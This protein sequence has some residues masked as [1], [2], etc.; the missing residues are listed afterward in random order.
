MINK[1]KLKHYTIKGR[2]ILKCRGMLFTE[3]CHINGFDYM[4]DEVDKNYLYNEYGLTLDDM[5]QGFD[6]KIR[7]VCSKDSNHIMW[8]KPVHRT[9]GHWNCPYC[10]GRIFDLNKR[11]VAVELPHLLDE[12]DYEMNELKPSEVSTGS[13]DKCW[14][15]CRVCGESF[16]QSPYKR[17]IG[18]G[19]PYCRNL[20][21]K[22]GLNDLFTT[23]SELKDEWDWEYNIHINPYNTPAG[24]DVKVGWVCKSGH[25]WVATITSRANE[26][27]G[28][29][30][31]L[32]YLSFPERALGLYLSIFF[33][34]VYRRF[35][36]DGYEYDIYMPEE[37]IAIEFNGDYWHR[38]REERD[39]YKVELARSK[40]IHFIRIDAVESGD[41]DYFEVVTDNINL[42]YIRCYCSKGKVWTVTKLV[43][44]ISNHI[45][46]NFNVD[47]N[48]YLSYIDCKKDFNIIE[49][50]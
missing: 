34:D 11:S 9:N 40:K 48:K 8:F 18:Q 5:T 24:C 43:K 27:R 47:M 30:F 28:C 4:I 37:N 31:C 32:S 21:I 33:T 50:F 29:P 16:M 44:F 46:L 12:W 10:T 41:V 14:W 15:I 6:R 49:K 3:W 39:A 23:H 1:S 7:W 26:H 2:D 22:Q 25:R 13:I 35:K 42:L 36:L 17:R 19:C 38:G 45:L 20:K